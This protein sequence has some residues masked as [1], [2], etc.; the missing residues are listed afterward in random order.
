[1]LAALTLIAAGA[2]PYLYCSGICG[3]GVLSRSAFAGATT[4]GW[5]FLL[6]GEMANALGGIEV[7]AIVAGIVLVVPMSRRIPRAM[8]SGVLLSCAAQ[9]IFLFGRGVSGNPGLLAYGAVVGML[10]GLL[11][12]LAG[13]AHAGTLVARKPLQ[14]PEEPSTG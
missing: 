7:L 12:L 5:Q 14:W 10:A 13:L 2:L 11:L 9:T 6:E 1:M 4:E 3:T 8:A